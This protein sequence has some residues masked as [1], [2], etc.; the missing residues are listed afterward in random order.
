[1]ILTK[2]F[3]DHNFDLHGLAVMLVLDTVTIAATST[4]CIGFL[5]LLFV[6]RTTSRSNLLMIYL[7]FESL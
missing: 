4:T 3:G 7:E 6:L 5:G 1:M 2:T